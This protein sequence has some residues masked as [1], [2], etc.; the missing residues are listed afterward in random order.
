MTFPF[1]TIGHSKRAIG[2]FIDLLTASQIGLVVDVRTVPRSRTN[3][4]YNREALPVS[5]S[6]FQIAYEHIAE[7]GG[8]RPRAHDIAPRVNGF[9]KNQSFHNYADY[10]WGRLPVW[11]HPVAGTGQ[12]PAL[13]RDVL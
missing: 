4:Q 7:L 1:F 5:L 12:R 8:L 6:N 13:R 2:E 11:V 3:P 9:W 10:A